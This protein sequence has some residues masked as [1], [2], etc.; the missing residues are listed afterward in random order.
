MK[1]EAPIT[2]RTQRDEIDRLIG[3]GRQAQAYTLLG[4]LWRGNPGPANAG[5]IVSRWEKMRPIGVTVDAGIAITRSFTI[6][7]AISVLRA[8]AVVN[9]IDLTVELGGF[10]TYA[11]EILDPGSALYRLSPDIVILAIQTRDIAPD[12]WNDFTDLSVEQC[13]A[14]IDRV[15]TDYRQWIEAFRRNSKATLIV[16]GL[17]LPSWPSW[18]TLDGRLPNSQAIGIRHINDSLRQFATEQSGVY[19]LDY[20]ALISRCGR[21]RW[22]DESK[23]QS[24]RMPIAADCLVHMAN[25]WLRFIHPLTGR[26]CKV[27]VTDLDNT[28]WGGIVGEDGIHGIALDHEYPG[29]AYRELQRVMLDVYQRG[30]L[31]AI[32]SKNN[33]EDAMQVLRENPRMLLRPQHFAAMRINWNDKAQGLREIAAELNVGTEALAFVDD[34]PAE[35]ERIRC[36]MPEVT[37]IELPADP[38]AFAATVRASPVFERLSLSAEDRNRSRYYSEERQRSELQKESASLEDFYLSLQ[39]QIDIGPIVAETVPRVAQLTQKTNQFNLTSFR[40]SEQQITQLASAPGCNIMTV[41]ARDRFGD[42]GLVGVAITKDVGDICEIDTFLLSCRVIGRGIE[43]AMLAHISERAKSSGIKELSGR[44]I[45]TKK[46]APARDFYASHGFLRKAE[47][48][49]EILWSREI[50]GSGI[51]WPTWIQLNA[52]RRA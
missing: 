41:S 6:E 32:C 2:D 27:L 14:A 24:M 38:M 13:K 4:A 46:N 28:L 15:S 1:L 11:Q 47:D 5:F 9:G 42:A 20:D 43:T 21:Q 12:L 8:A 30:I 33:L 44:F 22:L 23:W 16:H 26:I 10:N 29:A 19:V 34:N 45:P 17:E 48:D 18:G 31:L 52:R 39:Q 49:G 36:T 37:V 35:C 50:S 7:P 40:Y 3:D 51:V 25:E